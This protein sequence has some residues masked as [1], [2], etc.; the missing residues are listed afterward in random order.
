MLKILFVD[1]EAQILSSLRRM[2]RRHCKEHDIQF[3][4]SGPEA[5]TLLEETA[6]DVIFSD[7][8]MPMM[9][10]NEFLSQVKALYPDTV[11]IALSGY[12]E[13]GMVLESIRTTHAFLSKPAQDDDIVALISRFS[14]VLHVINSPQIRSTLAGMT[15]LPVLPEIYQELTD[16]LE[17]EETSLKAVSAIISKDLSLCTKL[18]QLANSAYF[19]V[20]RECVVI[21][22]AVS[23]LGVDILRNLVLGLSIF[24]TLSDA[25]SEKQM[26]TIWKRSQV[27]A[28]IVRKIALAEELPKDQ[29]EV[30]V[31]AAILQ[32]LGEVVLLANDSGAV[33]SPYLWSVFEDSTVKALEA[34]LD[35]N[36]HTDI[37]VYLLSLW[38]IPGPV[39]ECVANQHRL[40][41]FI[42]QPLSP[43]HYLLAANAIVE[44]RLKCG[45]S[46]LALFNSGVFDKDTLQRWYH[47]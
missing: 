28:G 5:L 17:E 29:L 2:L 36:D 20:P 30:L 1:D 34:G 27:V 45:K 4:P 35:G 24:E 47:L 39:I 42:N 37:A 26:T 3:C 10:G 41:P 44:A 23:F 40:E 46:L 7:M 33:T 14:A 9:S 32:D 19:G 12:A 15:S 8:R 13:E 16:S 38:G 6:F 43:G 25:D 21:E 22:D 31:A 11:R 18:L